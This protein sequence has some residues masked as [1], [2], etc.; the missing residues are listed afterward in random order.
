MSDS[1]LQRLRENNPFSSPASPLPWNNMNPDLQNLNRE[2]SDEIE[3]LIRQK[4]LNPAVPLGGLVLGEAGSGKTHMLTRILRKLR[5]NSQLAV[6]VAVRAFTDPE[7]VTQHLLSEIFNSLR[8]IHSGGRS[9][10]DMIADEF[11]NA[12]TERRRSDGFDSIE[13]LDIRPYIKKDI[14][15]IGR[16]F[17]KCLLLYM[18][19]NDEGTKAD[20]LDWLCSGLDDE[21]SLRLGLPPRNPD[22]MSNAKLEQDAENILISLGLVLSY[23]K[24]PMIICF[25]QLDG[26]KDKEE[27]RKLISAWGNIISLLMN[28]LAGILPLCFMKAQTW[29]DVFLPVLDEA[30]VQRIKNNTMTMRE[31]SVKQARQL[32]HDRISATFSENTEEIYSWL[33]SKLTLTPG[34][35]PRDV[36]QLANNAIT[37]SGNAEDEPGEITKSIMAVFN[38]EYKKVQSVPVA[39]PP[40]AEHLTL[41]LE[42][43]L[44]SLDG[45]TVSKSA[46]KYIRLTGI[47]GSR[48]FA[49]VI[50]IPKAHFTASAGLNE[51]LKFMKEY[52]GSFCCYVLEEKSH[53]P[54]W[55]K[56]AEKLKEFENAGG[57]VAR[58]GKDS[59][60]K[61]YALTALINR[62]DNGDVNI[63]TSSRSRTA[64]RADILPFVRTLKLIDSNALKFF[65]ASV[66]YSP[67]SAK[68]EPQIYFDDK[69]SADTLRSIISASPV[70]LLTADKAAALLTQRGISLS[71]NDVI[72]FVRK[73]PESFRTYTSKSG[74]ILITSAEK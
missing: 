4:R 46:G 14:P 31:C 11:M 29:N 65:P 1:I 50:V 20:I 54:T 24:V 17:L 58:L 42:L 37:S 64:S 67:P 12:Y 73:N 27:P 39:W 18:S 22:M 60:V 15:N 13:N 3:Q 44:S 55:K 21:D 45:F 25:D 57:F 48:K 16:N 66:T 28:D 38:D 53:K 9:Q 26:I 33:V 30:V 74:D 5:G 51:G 6:F 7:S 40:N 49:F 8:L 59:R 35:S 32:I 72:A 62:V 63:Y 69:L 70:K 41:A 43:W 34:L 71:R 2:T 10:F 23:A 61:W 56:F 47:H 19:A 68:T 36:I 52:P